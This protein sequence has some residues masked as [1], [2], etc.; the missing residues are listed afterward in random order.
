MFLG[1]MGL[2]EHQVI[3]ALRRDTHT[4]AIKAGAS[5]DRP[6]ERRDW[7]LYARRATDFAFSPPR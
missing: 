7:D 5:A 2:A 1:E 3:Y 6:G 4:N